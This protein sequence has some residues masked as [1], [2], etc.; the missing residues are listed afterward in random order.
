VVLADGTTIKTRQR[1]KKLS[2]G[3]D[4]TK[5]FIESEGILGLV[6]EAVLKVTPLPQYQRV[7]VATFTTIQ[8]AAELVARVV[9]S[10]LP[11]SGIEIMDDMQMRVI[12]QSKVTSRTWIEATT[13][14]FKFSGTPLGVTEQIKIVKEMVKD[15]ISFEFATSDNE[16]KEMWSARKEP[17]RVFLL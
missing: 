4:L 9:K 2:T 14:F 6:I 11:L 15:S 13:L 3:H 5:L 17:F 10:G 8:E 7:A 1:S 12:N 16:A